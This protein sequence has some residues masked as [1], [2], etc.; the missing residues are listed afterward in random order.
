MLATAIHARNIVTALV[1]MLG[2]LGYVWAVGSARQSPRAR[3]GPPSREGLPSSFAIGGYRID[4]P[5]PASKDLVELTPTEYKFFARAFKNERT[6]KAPS[7]TFLGRLW[8]VMLGTVDGGVYKV[9]A[10][11]ELDDKTEAERLIGVAMRHC[12][13]Q[14]GKPTEEKPGFVTWDTRDGNVILQN[15][16]VMGTVSINVFV[17][18]SAVHSF[19]RL[20]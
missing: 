8:N 18:A 13:S 9:A 12:T 11:V 7:A 15:A 1:L 2:G 19:T 17:T 5:V 14:L 4:A 10:F 6:Y 16:S 3:S 20:K